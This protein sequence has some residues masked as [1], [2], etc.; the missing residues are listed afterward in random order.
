MKKPV[1]ANGS[2]YQEKQRSVFV[3]FLLGLIGLVMGITVTV[4]S[5][6]VTVFS[7]LLRNL[8]LF[9]AV[10]VSWLAVRRVAKGVTPFYNYGYGKLESLSSLVVAAMMIVS[11]VIIVYAVI[12]RLQHPASLG[13][14]GVG[15]GVVF[16]GITGTVNG[17]MWYRNHQIAKKQSSPIIESLWRLYR[18]KTVSTFCVFLTLGLSLA[19]GK[20]S[21]AVYI[22]PAGSIAVLG[23]LVFSVYGVISMSVNDLLDRTLDESLQLVIL[24]EMATFFEEYVAIH[25]IKSRRS[26]GDI[27]IEILLEFD[28]DR[29]MTEVQRAINEMKFTLEQKIPGSHVII[30]PTMRYN[31]IE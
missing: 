7:D 27:Y 20:Y 16:S 29:K 5:N 26:G 15:L 11:M 1:P 14:V 28:G 3:S 18:M 6:S 19:F 23:F 2:S 30:A 10:L 24:R 4:L 17:W 21:W 9:V 25:G 31:Y 12:E 8:S 22:D 13:E